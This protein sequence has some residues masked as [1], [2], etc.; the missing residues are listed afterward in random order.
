M[1]LIEGELIEQIDILDEGWWAGV[2]PGGKQGLFPAN[3]VEVVEGTQAQEDAR[4]ATPPPPS[5]PPPPPPP[6][7]PAPPPVAAAPEPEP[8]A[9]DVGSWALALYE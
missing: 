7:A 1:E 9:E 3:Y 8:A 4:P 6:P 5:P 2:G